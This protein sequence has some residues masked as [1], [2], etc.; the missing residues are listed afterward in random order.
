MAFWRFGVVRHSVAATSTMVN[1]TSQ[2]GG[3]AVIQ[4]TVCTVAIELAL[5]L[6]KGQ[7]RHQE[8][9]T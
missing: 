6:E 3:G 4:F 5:A 8:G 2:H 9:E 1:P 7:A